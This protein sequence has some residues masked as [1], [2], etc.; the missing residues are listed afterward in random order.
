MGLRNRSDFLHERCFFVTTT[1]VK[2][3]KLIEHAQAYNLIM[4]SLGFVNEKYQADLLGYV[5][6][7]NHL[8]LI[9]Y[10]KDLN[11]LSDYMRDFKKFTSTQIRKSL[12]SRGYLDLIEKI[13]VEE[14][15]RQFQV[16]Q[17][18]F[19]DL[20]LDNIKMLETKLAYIHL[21]PLQKHWGLVKNPEDYPYSSAL[22]YE[23][24][25]LQELQVV[26]YLEYF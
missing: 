5:I 22:F 24:G 9:L 21:N 7:P 15:N 6:M 8:H 19:D 1:C 11:H 2:W 4:Q 20:Y 18:R 12:E 14:K 25:Q 10:F 13:R 26:H 16:W 3:L 23:K 17:N